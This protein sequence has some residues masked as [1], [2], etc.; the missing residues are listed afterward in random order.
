MTHDQQTHSVFLILDFRFSISDGLERSESKIRNPK[1]KMTW[2]RGVS[3]WSGQ[4]F[5]V[6]R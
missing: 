1:S 4:V 2:M 6:Q 5:E 3:M